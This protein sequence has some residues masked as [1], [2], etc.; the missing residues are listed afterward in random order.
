ML[1]GIILQTSTVEINKVFGVFSI[2]IDSILLK[3]LF[4]FINTIN[5]SYKYNIH[6]YIYENSYTY[7]KIIQAAVSF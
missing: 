4:I 7:N 3:M 5:N 6:A 2:V 1:T